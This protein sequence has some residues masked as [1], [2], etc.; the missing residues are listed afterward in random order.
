MYYR[1]PIGGEAAEME[2]KLIGALQ[3]A[4]LTAYRSFSLC[5]AL[6]ALPASGCACHGTPRCGCL[7][8]V[9]LAYGPASPPVLIVAHHRDRVLE[10]EVRGELQTD[11]ARAVM[12]ALLD[13]GHDA[14][15][16]AHPRTE[17]DA[18][19]KTGSTAAADRRPVCSGLRVP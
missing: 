6:R 8:S 5:E 7:Y 10:V 4:G 15:T 13:F 9:F 1:M 3:N 19:G 2:A 11:L 17:P 12:D 18:A 16:R 14:M